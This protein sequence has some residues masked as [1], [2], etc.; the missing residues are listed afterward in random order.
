MHVLKKLDVN[1]KELYVEI[2]SK[3]IDF[4]K[5]FGEEFG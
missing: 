5:H 4:A 2:A 3:E 1:G